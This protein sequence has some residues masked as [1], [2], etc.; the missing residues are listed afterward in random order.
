M[1]FKIFSKNIPNK[2]E[3]IM[4]RKIVENSDICLTEYQNPSLPHPINKTF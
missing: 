4:T 1:N 2:G 3:I